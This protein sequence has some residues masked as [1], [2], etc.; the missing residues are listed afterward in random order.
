MGDWVTRSG[1]EN[2]FVLSTCDLVKTH[3]RKT[4][5]QGVEM[6]KKDKTPRKIRRVPA[7]RQS[8]ST[9]YG[10]LALILGILLVALLAALCGMA[11][12]VARLTVTSKTT[13]APGGGD[14][15]D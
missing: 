1:H 6:N 15:E 7:Q 9:S 2:Y 8:N 4:P 14:S 13:E 12:A 11:A 3:P 5:D 10:L